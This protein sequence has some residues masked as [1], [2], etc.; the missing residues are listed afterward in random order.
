[1]LFES[2]LASLLL[3]GNAEGSSSR[4]TSSEKKAIAEVPQD[5]YL[6]TTK[7][8]EYCVDT[9]FTHP[10]CPQINQANFSDFKYSED[11]FA[12][13][14]G[15]LSYQTLFQASVLYKV[16]RAP[17]YWLVG[18]KL[19]GKMPEGLDPKLWAE[20]LYLYAQVLFDRKDYRK[21]LSFF[22]KI[23]DDFKGRARFHQ[24]RAWAQYFNK[25]F[26]VA[27][28]SIMSASSPII[29]PAPFFDRYFLRALIEKENC[30]YDKAIET[31]K[32]GR[33]ELKSTEPDAS[34]HPWVILCDRQELGTTCSRLRS[35]YH[36]SYSKQ[37]TSALEDL[38]LLEIELRDRLTPG[39][40]AK[41]KSTIMWPFVGENWQDELGFY[42]IPIESKCN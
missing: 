24:Q 28:G 23:V 33:T 5:W 30:L 35:W 19:D 6:S 13:P 21:S 29:Y 39:Q 22:D 3:L 20:A 7:L 16:G 25:K 32:A 18:L 4:V 11:F 38:D 26:D 40:L 10:S 12:A 37:I 41:S 36:R 34:K 31:I 14:I 8:F 15:P 1:M 27:L 9:Q 17:T 2:I 42:S